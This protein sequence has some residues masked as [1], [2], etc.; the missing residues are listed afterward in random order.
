MSSVTERHRELLPHVL[1][2]TREHGGHPPWFGRSFSSALAEPFGPLPVRK[3]IA[4]CCADFPLSDTIRK[5]QA[6]HQLPRV[7]VPPQFAKLGNIPL[8]DFFTSLL[9]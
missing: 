5:R 4:L 2:L 7:T 9:K 6:T 3:R 8:I 1:T